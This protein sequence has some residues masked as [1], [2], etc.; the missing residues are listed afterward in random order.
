MNAGTV[1]WRVQRSTVPPAASTAVRRSLIAPG[2]NSKV[3]ASASPIE[4]GADNA[5]DP[6]PALIGST[7]SRSALA[8]SPCCASRPG[9]QVT[10]T[11]VRPA[12]PRDAPTHSSSDDGVLP[13]ASVSRALPRPGISGLPAIAAAAVI[14]FSAGAQ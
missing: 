6:S 12:P 7:V 5:V 8:V 14:S 4:V 11:R 13:P 1:T 3:A 2:D 9:S 10:V